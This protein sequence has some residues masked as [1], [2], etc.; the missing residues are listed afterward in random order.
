MHA[1]VGAGKQHATPHLGYAGGLGHAGI[2]VRVRISGTAG[3]HG[4][5]RL[6]YNYYADSQLS[7]NVLQS[8][9]LR[10]NTS[11]AAQACA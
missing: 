5:D 10:H 11:V 2:L 8:N 3:L 7:E 4:I 6:T 1:H 9:D